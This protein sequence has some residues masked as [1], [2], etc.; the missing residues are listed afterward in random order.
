MESI[1]VLLSWDDIEEIGILAFV[2]IRY[3]VV[4]DSFTG[5]ILLREGAR[6]RNDL[7]CLMIR[8]DYYCTYILQEVRLGLK[9]KEFF[10]RVNL[11][12]YFIAGWIFLEQSISRSKSPRIEIGIDI[13]KL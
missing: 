10:S 8:L 9:L 7:T 5:S 4:L 2:V 12:L 13:N 3:E 6:K 1:D 11:S